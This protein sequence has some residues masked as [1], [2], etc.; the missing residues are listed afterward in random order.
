MSHVQHFYFR[1]QVASL[2]ETEKAVITKEERAAIEAKIKRTAS[3]KQRAALGKAS[4]GQVK[5]K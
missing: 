2:Y 1:L 5:G 4:Q 3:E